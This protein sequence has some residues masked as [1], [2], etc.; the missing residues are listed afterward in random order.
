MSLKNKKIKNLVFSGCSS[1]FFAILGYLK[2]LIDYK[3]F[4]LGN[5]DNIV[6]S[7]GSVLILFPYLLGYT[8]TEIKDICLGINLKTLFYENRENQNILDNI[9][10]KKCIINNDKFI[11]CFEIFI[12][13]K[14]G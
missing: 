13:K 5:I 7:S 6:C 8:L 12:F 4:E 3:Y 10:S 1:K 9:F 11:K 2:C 14:T